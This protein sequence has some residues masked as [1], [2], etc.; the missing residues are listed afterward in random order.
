MNRRE[1]LAERLCDLLELCKTVR[2][3][4]FARPV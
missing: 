1:R 4:V 2:L 3:A